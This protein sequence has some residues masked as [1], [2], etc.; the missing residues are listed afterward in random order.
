MDVFYYKF[1]I[2]I[3][4]Y[5]IISVKKPTLYNVSMLIPLVLYQFCSRI[6]APQQNTKIAYHTKY[7]MF[8]K[9]SSEIDI[10]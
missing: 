4:I 5:F 1:H 10:N 2:I 7:K 6:L 8:L 3:Y 9:L